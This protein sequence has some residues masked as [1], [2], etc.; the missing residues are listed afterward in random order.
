MAEVQV[1]RQAAGPRIVRV[2]A[3]VGV[4]G[5]VAPDE[6]LQPG[7]PRLGPAPRR[8]RRDVVI[9]RQARERVRGAGEE[10]RRRLPPAGQHRVQRGRRRQADAGERIRREERRRGDARRVFCRCARYENAVV[11]DPVDRAQRMQAVAVDRFQAHVEAAGGRGDH[12]RQEEHRRVVGDHGG[13][14]RG[15]R[16]EQPAALAGP[17]LDVGEVARRRPGEGPGVVGHALQHE[18][19]QAV[20]RPGIA[21][22]ERLEDD[23]R[24]APA[25]LPARPRVPGRSWRAPGAPRPSSRGRRPA[26]DGPARRWRDG[27]APA[28]PVECP[29]W[30]EALS[31]GLVIESGRDRATACARRRG[32]PAVW[33]RRGAARH[34]N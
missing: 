23:Q 8:D 5:E 34:L 15:E 4:G 33:R 27:S 25:P 9:D 1:R 21:D 2:V 20:A 31:S 6:R 13:G 32:S 16:L 22:T 26:R 3:I 19:V 30:R 18:G 11:E 28:A 24:P 17:G 29:R 7:L 10:R 12:P 14:V